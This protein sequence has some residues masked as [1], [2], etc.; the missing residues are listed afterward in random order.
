M[1][2]WWLLHVDGNGRM[3]R[4]TWRAIA[5]DVVMSRRLLMLKAIAKMVVISSNRRKLK[6]WRNTAGLC[7]HAFLPAQELFLGL[8]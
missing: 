2:S 5:K 7:H 6:M 4:Q 3:R 1:H 8:L